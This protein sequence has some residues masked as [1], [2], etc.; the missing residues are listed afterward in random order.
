MKTVARMLFRKDESTGKQLQSIA[1]GVGPDLEGIYEIVE[2]MGELT[3]VRIG[4][5]HMDK[6]CIHE[7]NRLWDYNALL[8]K[9]DI[10]VCNKNR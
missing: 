2:V 9:E 4:D 8:T 6:V 7:P 3:V 1:M 10:E 5:S